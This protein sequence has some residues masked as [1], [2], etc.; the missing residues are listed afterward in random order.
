[1]RPSKKSKSFLLT[2]W[3]LASGLA[4]YQLYENLT[5]ARPK[6]SLWIKLS[7]YSKYSEWIEAQAKH[8]TNNYTSDVFKR[9]NNLFGMKNANKRE[10]LGF[11]VEGDPYRHY[12]NVGDSIRDFLML[13]RYN[14]FPTNFKT[15][16]EFVSKLKSQGYFG[17]TFANYLNGV[18]HFL[19]NG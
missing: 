6:K 19:K 12:N 15:P 14:R 4:I 7:K 16:T 17:D 5:T 13:L 18:F 9:A 1:M 2:S 10:Q 11:K 3:L 8:E